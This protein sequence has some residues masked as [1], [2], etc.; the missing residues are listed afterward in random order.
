MS[1]Y[2]QNQAQIDRQNQ[3]EQSHGMRRRPIDLEYQPEPD[4]NAP[5]ERII[6]SVIGDWKPDDRPT[7]GDG[8]VGII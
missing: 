1:F 5:R 8:S 7:H 4:P 3:W 2:R 6:P